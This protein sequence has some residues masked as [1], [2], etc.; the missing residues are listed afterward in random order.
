MMEALKGIDF[1]GT[2]FLRCMYRNIPL[3]LEE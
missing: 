1:Q 3:F 2:L